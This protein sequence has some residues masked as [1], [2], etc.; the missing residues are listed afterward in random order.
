MVLF[1]KT[2]IRNGFKTGYGVQFFTMGS[3]SEPEEALRAGGPEG[4]TPRVV[5]KTVTVLTENNSTLNT[6]KLGS[7]HESV[8]GRVSDHVIRPW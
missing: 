8:H 2:G 7:R 3:R 6:W 1:V 4:R 5:H